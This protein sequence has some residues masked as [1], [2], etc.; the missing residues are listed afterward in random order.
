[1]LRR[2]IASIIILLAFNF[3]YKGV[4]YFI[5]DRADGE[6][7]RH[8]SVLLEYTVNNRYGKDEEHQ[9][10]V[11]APVIGFK[12]DGKY[13]EFNLA[14]LEMVESLDDGDEVTVLYDMTK[15]EYRVATIINYWLTLYDIALG[16]ALALIGPVAFAIFKALKKWFAT[17]E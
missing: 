2:Y 11:S 14:D 10:W 17:M 3:V 9:K 15:D 4:R 6:V 5:Y 16:V 1:M 13:V 12:V 8:E 7:V